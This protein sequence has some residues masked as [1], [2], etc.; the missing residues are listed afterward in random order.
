MP[1][2]FTRIEISNWRALASVV[3]E[4]GP[5]LSWIMGSNG[6]GKSSFL[7]AI[8]FPCDLLRYPRELNTVLGHVARG[9]PLG[10]GRWAFAD[11]LRDP[12][13]PAEWTFE[14]FDANEQEWCY[15]LVISAQSS[16]FAIDDERLDRRDGEGWTSVL[17]HGPNGGRW[18]RGGWPDGTWAPMVGMPTVPLL[19]RAD[20]PIEHSAFLAARDFLRG[21]WLF[22]P[23][24]L[25]MR[26]ATT[27][28]REDAPLDRY[29]RDLHAYLE[30]TISAHPT[31]FRRLVESVQP[32]AGWRAIR[33]I[34]KGQGRRVEF[35][36][37]DGRSLALDL[38]SDG[39]LVGAW[40]AAVSEFPPV[41]WTVA[42]IDEPAVALARGPQ[43][44]VFD[45]LRT[46]SDS[47]FVIAATHDE[48]AVN[49][50]SRENVWVVARAPGAAPTLT[51]LGETEM[52]RAYPTMF[53][54]GDV[55][56]RT[57]SADDGEA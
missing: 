26:G 33:S 57:F 34:A 28:Y 13:A 52:A 44:E 46:L 48:H 54:A 10:V 11:L 55:A 6:S 56:V 36:E 27:P 35:E 32:V 14:F 18:L 8:V 49:L 1:T 2:R 47:V 40:L 24:P 20:D 5:D 30:A 17:E 50:D 39:Q 37:E 38:A 15:R 45:W 31:E 21:V 3:F 22:H 7:D 29:G 16:G 9:A 41:E 53:K 4:P 19:A 25:L 12:R 43:R 51:R 23:D 42:L